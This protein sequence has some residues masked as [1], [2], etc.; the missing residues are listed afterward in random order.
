MQLLDILE[1]ADLKNYSRIMNKLLKTLLIIGVIAILIIM[2]IGG[3]PATNSA[4]SFYIAF[5]LLV[6]GYYLAN[7]SNYRRIGIAISIGFPVAIVRGPSTGALKQVHHH[8]FCLVVGGSTL[9]PFKA[10]GLVRTTV[11]QFE[12]KDVIVRIFPAA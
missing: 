5:L 2:L 1:L 6:F 3:V 4:F 7:Y 10:V 11:R 8:V 12:P 9:G